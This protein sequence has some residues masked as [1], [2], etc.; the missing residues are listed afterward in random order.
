MSLAAE[1]ADVVG[2]V[3]V[4]RRGPD[5]D[6][7][8]EPLGCL[9]RGE[10]ADHRADRVADEDDVVELQLAADLERRPSA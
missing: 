7:R 2:V 6:Q 8:A 5:Q 10:H 3:D 4:A 9:V 1:A